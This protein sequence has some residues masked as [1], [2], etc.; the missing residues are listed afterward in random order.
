MSCV[1]LRITNNAII[2]LMQQCLKM[3]KSN[4]SKITSKNSIT[5]E[6]RL[7]FDHFRFEVV[8]LKVMSK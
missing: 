1:V 7:T 6:I 4:Y 5:F 2:N 3:F 8:C